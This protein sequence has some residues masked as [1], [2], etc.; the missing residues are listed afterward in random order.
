MGGI[1]NV[2][3]LSIAEDLSTLSE[4][5]C[6]IEWYR[7]ACI[8]DQQTEELFYEFCQLLKINDYQFQWVKKEELSEKIKGIDFE[9]SQLW[10]GI[11]D[12]PDRFKVRINTK[13]LNKALEK[14][15]DHL[16]ESIFHPAFDGAFR[17][18]QEEKI[19]NH[20]TV[21]AMYISLLIC[22]AYLA[23]EE[24]LFEP[25][26]RILESGHAPIGMEGNIVYF[27]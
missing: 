9:G 16:P 13:G 5:L 15:V 4:K 18:F 10:E 19:V 1:Y 24:S 8:Q 12:L 3:K 14:I 25:I 27:I 17:Q 7:K 20:L 22:C 11:K 2:L 26:L 6:S 21:A 23:G